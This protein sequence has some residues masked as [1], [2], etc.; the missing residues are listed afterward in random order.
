MWYEYVYKYIE[1]YLPPCFQ[2]Q[3]SLS[4]LKKVCIKS[5]PSSCGILNGSVRIDSYK[6]SSK[7]RGRSPP[8]LMPRFMEMNCSTVGLSFTY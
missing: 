2:S 5:L 4:G 6:D 8:L 1:I 7:V 3:P